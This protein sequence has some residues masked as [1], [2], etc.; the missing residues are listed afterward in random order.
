M[1]RTVPDSLKPTPNDVDVDLKNGTTSSLRL[2]DM[3]HN[4]QVSGL[5]LPTIY[6]RHN[7]QVKTLK[8]IFIKRCCVCLAIFSVC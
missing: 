2:V 3:L 1:Y 8:F 5:W 6:P 7:T 4:T